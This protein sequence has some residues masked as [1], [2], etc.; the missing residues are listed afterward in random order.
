MTAIS[1]PY[2]EAVKVTPD[3]EELHLGEASFYDLAEHFSNQAHF[4]LLDSRTSEGGLGR[5]SFLT[6]APFMIVNSKGGRVSVKEEYHQGETGKNI[7][8]SLG[9]VFSQF[10]I[11]PGY[12]ADVAPFLGGGIGY[13]AYEL[14]REIEELPGRAFDDL[15]IPDCYVCFYNFVIILS[16]E[17]GRV[18]LAYFDPVMTRPAFP[19]E[20]IL[21]EIKQAAA[22]SYS[23][24]CAKSKWKGAPEGDARGEFRSDFSREA[25]LDAINRIKEYIFAGDIYQANMTQRFQTDLGGVDPWELYKRLMEINPAPFA[26]YLNF[27][28]VR[29]VSSSPERFLKVEDR[30]VETRPIKGTVRRGATPE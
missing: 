29:V 5:Y 11:P 1:S 10:Q 17:Q 20:A 2:E 7:F 21:R 15:K 13:F 3:I 26:C 16:H 28:G 19:K 27:D 14:G 9:Q 18:F 23:R 6:F 22:G 8:D 30:Y 24:D 12:G 4:A 25:Y